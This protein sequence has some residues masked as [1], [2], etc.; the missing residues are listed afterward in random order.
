[1]K[2]NL[3]SSIHW[4]T[5]ETKDV[6]QAREI[7]KD[8]G[9]DSTVDSIG[10]GIPFEQ[11]SNILFPATSTLHTRLRYQFFVAAIIY[12]MYLES[13][14][15]PL[16][17][18]EKRLYNLENGLMDILKAN[19]PEGGVI[20]RIAG[21]KLKYWPSQTYWGGLNTMRF[22][23]DEPVSKADIFDDLKKINEIKL[24]NDDGGEEG[25]S[26]LTIELKMEL[27]KITTALFRN[28]SFNQSTN[29]ELTDIEAKFFIKQLETIP[30]GSLSLLYQWTK[31][32][33]TKL[34]KIDNFMSIPVTGDADLD[35]LVEEAKNYS[36]VAMGISHAYRYALCINKSTHYSVNDK[37]NEWKGYAENNIK[38][39]DRWMKNNQSLKSWN[40]QHLKN[41]IKK[42]VDEPKI[43][44]DLE[45]M[46]NVFLD[47]W[48]K[49][50][51]VKVIARDFSPEVV[52]QEYGRRLN[53]SHFVDPLMT[54]P[55]N[56]KGDKYF[57]SLYNY[58]FDQGRQNAIDLVSALR[59]KQ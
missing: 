48:S 6:Q 35:D 18:P 42:F 47:L 22:F 29:F 16:K 46:F 11:I 5:F 27:K 58:R 54:I 21:A 24:V 8:L 2:S 44:S 31:L 39:L 12:K 30:I 10:L 37:K 1:M 7:L 25:N 52:T 50:K 33:L 56:T 38:N 23:S 59:K 53:R 15:Q 43:D 3:A 26:K 57:D 41:A 19:D 17:N 32:S 28:D 55:D 49:K 51:D 14:V 20:G 13:K 9:P 34:N 4:V 45:K 36:R 40:I